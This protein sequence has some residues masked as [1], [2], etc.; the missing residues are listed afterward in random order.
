MF[1]LGWKKKCAIAIGERDRARKERDEA[2]ATLEERVEADGI[3][4][5]LIL[6]RMIVSEEILV[7]QRAVN[8]ALEFR[9]SDG[10]DNPVAYAHLIA[11]LRDTLR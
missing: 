11:A 5:N 4:I 1:S 3:A 8:E 6:S 2:R 10:Q 7:K 9:L